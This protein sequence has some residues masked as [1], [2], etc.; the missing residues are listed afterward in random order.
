MSLF[1]ETAEAKLKKAHVRLMKNRLTAAYIGALMLGESSIMDEGSQD[2]SRIGGLA[3]QMKTAA[4]DGVNKMYWRE[5]VELQTMQQ[6][7][8][9]V[10]HENLHVFLRQIPRHMDLLGPKNEITEYKNNQIILNAAMD[11]V[12]ND[13][14]KDIHDKDS[15]LVDLPMGGLWSEKFKNWSTREVF[16]YLKHGVNSQGQKEGKSQPKLRINPDGSLSITVNG[17]EYQLG[18]SDGHD[19]DLFQ[20]STPEQIKEITDKIKD[21]I[22][23]GGLLAG[24]MGMEIPRAML[25]AM[26]PEVNW[27]DETKEFVTAATK[28]CDE[29]TYRKY[30]KHRIVDE[31]FLPSTESEK[32]GKICVFIDTSGSIG[33][34]QLD[35][36][37]AEIAGICELCQPEELQVGWW[38]YDMH[39]TQ[40]FHE[41]EY[42]NIRGLLK[43]KG[44]GGT[45]VGCVRDY[46]IE[47]KVECDCVVIFTDGY[48]EEN[49]LWDIKPPTLWLVTQNEHFKPM[50]GK[51]VQFKSKV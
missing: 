4:T 6:L 9:I 42:N 31:Y 21:A 43:P 48:V 24:R 3:K 51:V 1:K 27:A 8:G 40:V 16:H 11:Y 38:D 26:E 10:L 37:G 20:D 23:Q 15:E 29:Y 36:F 33:Q 18:G 30:N 22:H 32:V 28:G 45:R 12:V 5:F 7:C 49:P 50:A 39:G 47:N 14:I 35:E 44:G 25:E 2:A 17:K 34:A 46:I 13:I 19:N 41:G